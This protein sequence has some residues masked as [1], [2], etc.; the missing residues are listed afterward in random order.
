M[1]GEHKT[2]KLKFLGCY[3]PYFIQCKQVVLV[4]ELVRHCINK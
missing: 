4:G 2:K 1:Y 3:E